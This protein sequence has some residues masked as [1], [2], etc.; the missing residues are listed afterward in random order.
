MPK[1]SVLFP[2]YN[3]EEVYLRAAIESILN[4]TFKDFE[5]L[6]I[7]DASS[8]E[9]VAKVVKSYTDK[10]ISYLR[11]ERNL[12]ISKTRNR[13]MELA[14]GEYW[15]V[16]DHDDVAMPERFEKQVAFLNEHPDIG[17]V[18]SQ[19]KK[20]VSGRVIT[21]PTYDQEIKLALFQTCAVM[22]PASM[23]RGSVLTDNNVC[24][25]E[26]FSPS[27]DHALWWRLSNYTK[28]H[29]MPE[30]LLHYREHSE[31]TTKK[32]REKMNSATLAIRAFMQMEN[33]ALYNFFLL[34]ATHTTRY[35]LFGFV[36]FLTTFKKK[37][38]T[39]VMLFGKIP[40][41][42]LKQYIRLKGK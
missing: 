27:E 4:Q 16:M 24:Y 39:K 34:K 14:Q 26:E 19:F 15:A 5:F 23:L 17:V 12:G 36:P 40:L 29:N 38:R 10:R 21:N 28:F 22:H 42:T 33:P 41:V 20:I 37:N 35:L 25:E 32:Q 8:D 11:N 30:V 7:D 6:I 3:A 2:V 31:N 9:N 18:S 1:V 13:L